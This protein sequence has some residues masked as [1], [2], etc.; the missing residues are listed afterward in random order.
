VTP[1]A[2]ASTAELAVP[3]RRGVS[4]LW[5]ERPGFNP[6]WLIILPVVVVIVGILVTVFWL[7]FLQGLPGTRDAHFTVQNYI[8]LYTDPF[9]LTALTNT[10]GFALTSVFVGLFFGTAMAW[11]VERTNLP[12]K[13]FIYTMMTLGLLLPGF[14][15]AMGWLFMLHPRIGIINRWIM[16]L[17][18]MTEAPLS[19]TTVLG[20]GWVQGLSLGSLA[21]VLTS[22]SFRAM[23]PALEEAAK[24]HGAS[25]IS[26][27][28][29]VFVPLAFPGILAAGLYLFTIGIA[30]FDVPAI[31]GLSNRIYT[32][33][34]F[35]YS[36]SASADALPEYGTT[37]AMSSMMVLVAL[38]CTAW[39]GRIIRRSNQ[40]QVVT[41]KGY[42][43]HQLQLGKWSIAAWSFVGFY[44]LC[45]KILP[46]LLLVWA[47][48]LPFFQPPSGRA[49]A[50]MS[51]QNFNN[52][53]VD[54][55]WRGAS[56]TIVLMIAVP[57]L[58]L[59]ISFVFS[60]MIVRSRSRF[61]V[62]LDFFA[63]LPHA[64]PG[65]IFGVGALFVALFVL[66]GLPL[67]GSLML[68]VIV[69][70][71][72]RLSFGTRVLNSALIQIHHELEEAAAMSGATG[73]RIARSV[74]A[75]L[76]WPALL[77]GWLWIALTTYREL[78]V[79]TVLFTPDN[80]TLPVVVWNIWA[81][82][83]FGVASAISLVLLAFLLPL[84]VLYWI[85][86][87]RQPG[88]GAR[89]QA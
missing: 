59:I 46:L 77:N 37:A 55:V 29:R 53:P 23:D 9:V 16:Q 52:I 45:S 73:L 56:H 32:F 86:G 39:Y 14:F 1:E 79:A 7:S 76:V 34:T 84:I 3:A 11:L 17:T 68:L 78:T 20:M 2:P 63:F 36:K 8:N 4:G 5:L 31:I 18:G 72:D 83:N 89:G 69:Y 57:T 48:A 6:L 41:G 24:V 26:V 15:M 43:P 21:F 54:L 27:L 10:L 80:I 25:F 61:R 60:W 33:S 81:S 47:A 64:V 66:K 62:L 19:I 12:G 28:R 22:A 67:Y 40:Y 75:P 58:A 44:F 49:F 38:A 88:G 87:A 70:M 71:V 35:V 74:L 85:L 65:I 50:T 51:W 42:R 13:A 82:G 30:S